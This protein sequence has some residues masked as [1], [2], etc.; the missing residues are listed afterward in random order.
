MK[1]TLLSIFTTLTTCAL[2]FPAWGEN[3]A[4]IIAKVAAS[5]EKRIERARAESPSSPGFNAAQQHVSTTGDHLFVG[6]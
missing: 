2:A 4:K 5:L 6:F 1:T 3:D